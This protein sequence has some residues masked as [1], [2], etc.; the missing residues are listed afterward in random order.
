M[1]L[2]IFQEIDDEAEFPFLVDMELNR[3]CLSRSIECTILKNCFKK[4]SRISL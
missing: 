2:N 1:I 3:T 4:N